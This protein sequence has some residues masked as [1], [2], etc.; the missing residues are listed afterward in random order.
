MVFMWPCALRAQL[1]WIWGILY[2]EMAR[3]KKNNPLK[4][5]RIEFESTE[6]MPPWNLMNWTIVHLSR[7]MHK[8][9]AQMEN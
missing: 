5:Y 7:H 6:Q 9:T 1:R 2:M 3:R 4:S 8:R